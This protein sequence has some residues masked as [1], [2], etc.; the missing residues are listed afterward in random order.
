MKK[1][2]II[3]FS[4]DNECISMV[5]E[6]LKAK[7]AEV[8]RF[9]SD[10]YPTEIQLSINET[11]D[12]YKYI[13][14][15]PE[16]EVDTADITA[17]WY[18][19]LRLAHGLP[20]NMD[21]QLRTPSVNEAR[22]VFLG[23]LDSLDAFV[24]DN[25]RKIR[26]AAHKQIQLQ[27]ARKV[28]L[29]IPRTLMTNKP[30]DVRAFFPTCKHGMITKMLSSFAVYEDDIEKVVFTNL[31]DEKDLDDLDGLALCPMTF[32]ENIP[33]KL[34]LRVTVIGNKIFTA[35]ID[36]QS[37]IKAKNDWRRDGIGLIDAWE[38][39]QL[40][41]EIETKLLQLMDV[42]KLNYGAIDMILTPDNRYVFLE[43]NPGGEFFW[44]ELNNPKFPLS[45]SIAEVLLEEVP[46]R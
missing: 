18:R 35:S 32:Q 4:T 19:R 29:E 10:L 22:G 25:Y 6:A 37:N 24:F 1:I 11:S 34:E 41:L 46:H 9:N 27:T 45:R 44:L 42:F 16:G 21:P 2:L 23:Y 5:T 8:F 38:I 7:N 28:G 39:H 36:S 12:S 14:T 26:Y 33:K 43:I 30:E 13:I 15:L 17:V 20:D 31:V 3:T 40:P